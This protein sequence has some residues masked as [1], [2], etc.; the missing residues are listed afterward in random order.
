MWRYR[1]GWGSGGKLIDV[2]FSVLWSLVGIG[3]LMIR[4]IAS[5]RRYQ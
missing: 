1:G 4:F 5:D 2:G 3:V